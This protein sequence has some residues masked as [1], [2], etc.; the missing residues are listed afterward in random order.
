M[1]QVSVLPNGS[2]VTAP[3][4]RQKIEPW[5]TKELKKELKDNLE[6]YRRVLNGLHVITPSESYLSTTKSMA[7][8]LI[9]RTEKFLQDYDELYDSIESKR[10]ARIK[11]RL[12]DR[13]LT[14]L[15]SQHFK[16]YLPDN[17]AHGILDLNRI[18]PRAISIYVKDKGLGGSQ[19]FR[20][21]DALHRLFNKPSVEDP[22]K[23]YLHLAQERI[24]EIRLANGY[25]PSPSS[26]EIIVE[27]GCVTMNYSALKIIIPKFGIEYD[28]TNANDYITQLEDFAKYLEDLHNQHEETKKAAK[29]SIK[30]K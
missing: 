13:A 15:F 4:S 26:A 12:C 20:L 10:T 29:K 18:A 7:Q 6:F 11:P 1:S 28:L 16:R 5:T 9:T 17:G 25:K 30:T 22:S 3:I 2:T 21:D 8:E 27:N 24:A 23:T 19:F 14:D